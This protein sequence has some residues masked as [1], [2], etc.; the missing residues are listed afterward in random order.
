MLKFDVEDEQ[1]TGCF[2]PKESHLRLKRLRA[3]V[4]FLWRL[5]QPRIANEQQAC[6]PGVRVDEVAIC[7]EWLAEQIG[8][9]LEGISRP[10]QPHETD[11]SAW[12]EARPE[13]PAEGSDDASKRYIFGITLDQLDMLQRLVGMISAHGDVVIASDEA[14]FA[15]HTL[16]LIGDAIFNDAKTV[17]D[18]IHQVESQR[19]RQ[20]HGSQTVGEERAVYRTRQV[21]LRANSAVLWTAV[22]FACRCSIRCEAADGSN[23]WSAMSSNRASVPRRWGS[24]SVRYRRQLQPLSSNARGGVV[25]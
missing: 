19:L 13:T 16:P 1:R 20:T 4:Q 22:R 14:A 18:I 10:V 8:F 24:S 25:R 17:R 23:P 15:D 21:Q 2:L 5:T 3:H 12:E 11:A 6:M 9:A 7:L